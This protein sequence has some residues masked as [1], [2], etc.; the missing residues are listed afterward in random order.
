MVLSVLNFYECFIISSFLGCYL[1]MNNRYRKRYLFFLVVLLWGE[2]SVLKSGIIY[3]GYYS[4]VGIFTIFI[5]T[6]I[7]SLNHRFEQLL[8]CIWIFCGI[9]TIDNLVLV[10]ASV[11]LQHSFVDLSQHL[12]HHFGLILASKV[13]TTIVALLVHKWRKKMVVHLSSKHWYLLL[14]I[15]IMTFSVFS[16]VNHALLERTFNE[17]DILVVIVSLIVLNLSSLVLF[18]YFVEDSNQHTREHLQLQALKAQQ[19]NAE[20]VQDLSEQVKKMKHDLKHIL[21]VVSLLIENQQYQEALYLL[22]DYTETVNRV[23]FIVQSGNALLDYLLNEKSFQANTDN[24]YFQMNIQKTDYSFI[25][26]MDLCILLGNLLDNAFEHCSRK[27][28]KVY[29]EM[30]G[31]GQYLRMIVRNNIEGSVLTQNPKLKSTKNIRELHGYGIESIRSIVKKYNGYVEFEEKE[32]EFIC[33][34]LLY[35]E[36][37]RTKN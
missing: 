26:E 32:Q 24:I 4:F 31:V 35:M 15:T 14:T 13:L 1:H 22:T 25:S 12:E 28:K 21:K 23:P 8:I 6:N 3:E 2:I 7:F 17:R 20:F 16:I 29:L 11:V 27:D 10:C 18:L 36:P 30:N 5:Y 9:F 19:S 33:I 37:D 34:I